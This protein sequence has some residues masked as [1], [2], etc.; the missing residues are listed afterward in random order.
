MNLQGIQQ[1]QS[2]DHHVEICVLTYMLVSVFSRITSSTPNVSVLT[3]FINSS[4]DRC[5]GVVKIAVDKAGEKEKEKEDEVVRLDDRAK[6]EVYVCFEGP[7]GAHLKKEVRE[8]IWKGEYVEIFSLLPLE[9]FN[10]DKV[11]PSDSKKEKEEEEKRRYRLIPRSFS[12]WLQAFAILASVVG[13]KEPEHCYALF[14][15]MDAIGE[16]YR[17]YGGLAWLRYDEQFRQRK[18]LRPGMRWDHKDISLWMRLMAAPSQ[19]F[20]GGAGGT[21][22]GPS[23]IQK[24]GLCWQFNEGQCKF[25]AACRFK[26][27]CSGCGGHSL[28]KCFKKGRGK[29]GDRSGKRE[30]AGENR[31]D[32]AVFK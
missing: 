14:G 21:G 19:P 7:L 24:K 23:G 3:N 22:A 29:A 4:K 15:Y 30:D 20:R 17:T 12:N 25:G 27:E 28:S 2:D 10:L 31:G 11:K 6:S 8:K 9:K 1:T 18:A 16:A 5:S 32:G 26:H 13:E